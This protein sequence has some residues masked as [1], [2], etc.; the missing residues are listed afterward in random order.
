MRPKN[1]TSK[2]VKELSAINCSA[3]ARLIGVSPSLVLKTLKGQRRNQR[4]R[5]ALCAASGL[6]EQQI[7]PERKA[8]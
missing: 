4:V 2:V 5:R 6:T 1:W 3:V 8:S 7:W